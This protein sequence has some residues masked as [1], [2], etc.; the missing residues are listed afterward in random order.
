MPSQIRFQQDAPDG[1]PNAG[2][3][4]LTVDNTDTLNITDSTGITKP[5]G[6]SLIVDVATQTLSAAVA[7]AAMFAATNFIQLFCKFILNAGSGAYTVNEVLPVAGMKAGAL[8]FVNIE[9]AASANPTIKFWDTSTSG[10]QLMQ[11]TS[12]DATKQT[13]AFLVFKFGQ[14]GHWH[15]IMSGWNG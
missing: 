7:S 15:L 5:V 10:T 6:L 3:D 9:F 12:P 14:D 11:V 1:P 2:T 4:L 13:F 8:A